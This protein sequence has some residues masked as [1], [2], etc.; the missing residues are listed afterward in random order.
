MPIDELPDLKQYL[1]HPL[2]VE[3]CRQGLIA[4]VRETRQGVEYVIGEPEIVIDAVVCRG[5][6]DAAVLRAVATDNAD[7]VDLTLGAV[8]G[9]PAARMLARVEFPAAYAAPGGASVAVGL[10]NPMEIT[11][12]FD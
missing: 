10:P 12:R 1:L 4:H 7:A 8:A 6:A 11:R 9:Q 2:L 5:P 3:G